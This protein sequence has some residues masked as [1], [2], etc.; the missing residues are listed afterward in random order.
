MLLP[1]DRVRVVPAPTKSNAR[2]RE[3]Q[4]TNQTE[5]VVWHEAFKASTPQTR[6]SSPPKMFLHDPVGT[7]HL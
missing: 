1:I 6:P 3:L 5:G 4:M 7:S 2:T